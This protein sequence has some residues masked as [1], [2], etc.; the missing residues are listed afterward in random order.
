ME[1]RPE[2]KNAKILVADEDARSRTQICDLLR[3]A[4]FRNIEEAVNGEEALIKIGRTHPDVAIVDVWLSKVDG[5]GV[6]RNSA[7]LDFGQDKP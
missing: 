5:I 2:T 7:A 6:L 3:R 1:L 4:G